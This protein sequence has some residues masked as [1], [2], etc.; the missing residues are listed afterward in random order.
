MRQESTF[1][2]CK[3]GSVVLFDARVVHRGGPNLTDDPR[4]VIYQTFIKKWWAEEG[5]E[6]Y[7]TIEKDLLKRGVAGDPNRD[8]FITT[9]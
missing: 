7:N 6:T 5:Q 8:L 9:A 3:P 4:H 2:S 1:A